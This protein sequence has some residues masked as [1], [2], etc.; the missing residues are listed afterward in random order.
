M[1]MLKTFRHF[2]IIVI[3]CGLSAGQMFAQ[4]VSQKRG[5]DL[6][7]SDIMFPREIPYDSPASNQYIV[8]PPA[9][10]FLEFQENTPRYIRR[11]EF[12]LQHALKQEDYTEYKKLV[13]ELN[14]RILTDLWHNSKKS[15]L[16][17]DGIYWEKPD[18][19]GNSLLE[20]YILALGVLNAHII[21]GTMSVEDYNKT[22][23]QLKEIASNP[24]NYP[25]SLRGRAI[26]LLAVSARPQIVKQFSASNKL[27]QDITDFIINLSR[28]PNQNPKN[29]LSEATK[30]ATYLIESMA[31][32]KS[33]KGIEQIVDNYVNLFNPDQGH[34]SF[35]KPQDVLMKNLISIVIQNRINTDSLR[36]LLDNWMQQE[37]YPYPLYFWAHIEAG[38]HP[39]L[40]EKR[41]KDRIQAFIKQEYCRSTK[42]QWDSITNMLI[43]REMAL[44]YWKLKGTDPRQGVIKNPTDKSCYIA[45]PQ[46][47]DF[48]E[49]VNDILNKVAGEIVIFLIPMESVPSAMFKITTK[50]IKATRLAKKS[51]KS[52]RE[53]YHMSKAVNTSAHTIVEERS[54]TTLAENIMK[55]EGITPSMAFQA[56]H[57]PDAAHAAVLTELRNALDNYADTISV[58]S[59][60]ERILLQKLKTN[61]ILN[62]NEL[63]RLANTP[64][65]VTINGV[66]KRKKFGREFQ[67]NYFFGDTLTPD[68]LFQVANTAK[69]AENA[70][71]SGLTYRISRAIGEK[72]GGKF[73]RVKSRDNNL[74]KDIE[75]IVFEIE[76]P[77]GVFN[78]ETSAVTEEFFKDFLA[79][80]N[81]QLAENIIQW[82]RELDLPCNVSVEQVNLRATSSEFFKGGKI[83]NGL[84]DNPHFHLEILL[85]DETGLAQLNYVINLEKGTLNEKTL[86][87]QFS[88]TETGTSI[89]L[90]AHVST[91]GLQEQFEKHLKCSTLE[92]YMN[93]MSI[94][95]M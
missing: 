93:F 11:T 50:L 30:M 29:N 81:E 37:K 82:Y 4:P 77:Q 86:I 84:R 10:A 21:D 57:N 13:N 75:P 28:Y 15:N 32:L 85:K 1:H 59:P 16:S 9:Y 91:R 8:R 58:A 56:P 17:K 2:I 83:E 89:D 34:Y 92:N 33:T 52:L 76:S 69:L 31:I 51:N 6:T 90:G 5:E 23:R 47:P 45:Y 87:N 19:R 24:Q 60:N 71:Q 79:K 18:A 61:G 3:L 42:W 53:I 41:T 27:T 67:G 64:I 78:V 48:N 22:I 39:D 44:G 14:A 49:K 94:S 26:V 63:S 35:S 72:G 65:D 38:K 88:K 73:K 40:W 62:D 80:N 54:V 20:I 55:G 46:Q 70:P 74:E 25:L 7:L 66:V 36:Y 68:A 12:L 43:R 95:N